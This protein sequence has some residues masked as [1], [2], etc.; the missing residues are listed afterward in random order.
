VGQGVHYW[1]IRKK[2]EKDFSEMFWKIMGARG[3][4]PCPGGKG[5]GTNHGGLSG[6][7]GEIQKKMG[8]G[9]LHIGGKKNNVSSSME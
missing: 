6:S 2:E 3:D 4:W 5:G 7:G 8:G 1:G 9:H